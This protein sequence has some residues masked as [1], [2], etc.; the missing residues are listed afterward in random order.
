M[1]KLVALLLLAPLISRAQLNES[2]SDGNLNQGVVWMGETSDFKVNDNL[3]L[4]LN[5]SGEGYSYL[6]TSVDG[7]LLFEWNIWV[8]LS[9]SPS[10]NNQVIIYLISDNPDL[11]QPLS[12]YYIRVGESGSD[13]AIELYRQEQSDHILVARGNSGI[14]SDASTIRIKITRDDGHWQIFADPNGNSNYSIRQ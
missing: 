12:G 14:F 3:Q 1:K 7:N 4:Q 13:D 11:T 9:F 2:F 10:D 8:K 5:S 6:S